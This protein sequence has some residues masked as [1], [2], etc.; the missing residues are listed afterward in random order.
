MR[1]PGSPL[2]DRLST[3]SPPDDP[4]APRD[5]AA[6][7][8]AATL[9]GDETQESPAVASPHSCAL[10]TEDAAAA[11]TLTSE[12][13]E[14]TATSNS[15]TNVAP[16]SDDDCP[17]GSA[18]DDGK[19]APGAPPSPS[20][21][22]PAVSDDRPSST[23][24][25]ASSV[26]DDQ[27]SAPG[28]LSES[29]EVQSVPDD[30]PSR[31][32][33]SA[34]SGDQAPASDVGPALPDQ[35]QPRPPDDQST[36]PDDDDQST[37][38]DDQDDDQS[39]APDDQNEDQ[40]V[41][42]NEDLPPA[43]DDRHNDLPAGLDDG[44]APDRDR[45]VTEQDRGSQPPGKDQPTDEGSP[46]QWE[47]AAPGPSRPPP[48]EEGDS[49]TAR[50]LPGP[51]DDDLLS[52]SFLRSLRPSELSADETPIVRQPPPSS[53][54]TLASEF[55]RVIADRYRIVDLLARGGMGAV[56]LAEHVVLR[57]PVA[58]KL[59]QPQA[60]N[61]PELVERFQREAVVGAHVKH[62]NI[63]SATDFGTLEDGSYFLVLE[64][65]EGRPLDKLLATTGP[66]P[67]ERAVRIAV[68]IADAL[69]ALH[70]HGVVHRDLKPSNVMLVERAQAGRGE[71]HVKVIDF[72]LAKLDPNRLPVHD[73]EEIDPDD[74]LT[75]E[76]VVIG[77]VAYL[78]PE[79]GYGMHAVD[80]RSDLYALGLVLYRMLAGVHPFTSTD[81]VELF[82]KHLQTPPPPIAERAPGVVVPPGLEQILQR[83]LAKDPAA[84][85]QSAAEL[86][87]ALTPYAGELKDDS[88]KRLAQAQV[89]Q[90]RAAGGDSAG[91]P[92]AAPAPRQ[93]WLPWALGLP[94]TILFIALVSI[95]VRS[96]QP[97]GAVVSVLP[98]ATATAAQ[99]AAPPLESAAPS[100][101]Q[102]P[103]AASSAELSE[104]E[105][106]ALRIRFGEAV[107]SRAWTRAYE[108]FVRLSRAQPEFF[109]TQRGRADASSLLAA[110]AHARLPE[111][112]EMVGTLKHDLGSSGHD[113]LFHIVLFRGGSKAHALATQALRDPLVVSQLNEQLAVAVQL[114]HLGCDVSTDVYSAAV[115][116]GDERALM[117]LGAQRE[118][119]RQNDARDRAY[120]EL[121]Q[122]L[123]SEKPGGKSDAIP[124]PSASATSAHLPFRAPRGLPDVYSD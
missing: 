71:D 80:A 120:R 83:L 57:A 95:G 111:A 30:Q 24:N 10:G 60:S 114:L 18:K 69:S 33:D 105:N 6:H 13:P 66:L 113:I 54:D 42:P 43:P 84:R 67:T 124:H 102:P 115:A 41:A 107:D 73:E 55:G 46:S 68:Q 89:A 103:P 86:L 11:P 48:A 108:E 39:T 121:E 26:R 65:V 91:K 85:F 17:S 22:P 20:D 38:P 97:S 59:L 101:I 90:A 14:T 70:E 16:T 37:A 49:T 50:P 61:L 63:A 109:A 82:Q 88:S 119:C 15:G 23:S 45:V 58:L 123:V 56:Y 31:P 94:A 28:Q 100:S 118:R 106:L 19:P 35:N 96:R 74:R 44:R 3:V 92:G 64:L 53:A 51:T 79:A 112:N 122:R 25:D 40:T 32:H 93:S 12:D 1:V 75:A 72:G 29:D 8:A 5:E 7:N 87:E 27:P 116:R 76:G 4:S 2:G 104:E 9:V 47:P 36:A 77:T 117:M 81:D 98:S 34:S 52:S 110:L 62:P 78:A 99:T 21:S